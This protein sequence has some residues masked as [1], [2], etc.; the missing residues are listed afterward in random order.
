[1]TTEKPALRF[2]GTG[3]DGDMQGGEL[4]IRG[5]KPEEFLLAAELDRI[6]WGP[7]PGSRFVADGEHVWRHWAED[8]LALGAFQGEDL[9]GV[10]L[11]FPGFS[12][13]VCLHKM[14]IHPD[15]RG[16]GVGT[17]LL[18]EM[19]AE[20]DRRETVVY[21]TVDPENVAARK[22]YAGFGFADREFVP[23]YYGPGQDRYVMEREARASFGG[24]SFS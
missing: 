13:R 17:R 10:A 18:E 3:R 4:R 22:L 6:A 9:R 20:L 23:A 16:R 19:L 8:A 5:L 7:A 21:L 15:L 24:G 1:M 11:A 14:F 2:R 12:G